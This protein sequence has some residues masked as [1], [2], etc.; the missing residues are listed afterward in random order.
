MHPKLFQFILKFN[1]VFIYCEQNL[2]PFV[3]FKVENL[4][5]KKIL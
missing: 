4:S 3:W 2:Q 1:M 5:K